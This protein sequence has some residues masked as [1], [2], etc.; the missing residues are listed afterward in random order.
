MTDTQFILW[1]LNLPAEQ[2]M[3][4]WLSLGQRCQ[5][6]LPDMSRQ[7]AHRQTAFLNSVFSHLQ[8]SN[9]A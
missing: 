4:G 2:Q 1:M 5:K 8:V 7:W 3:L 6:V 9:A